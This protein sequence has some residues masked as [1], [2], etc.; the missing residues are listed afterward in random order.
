MEY[1]SPEQLDR[2]AGFIKNYCRNSNA[3]TASVLDPNANVESK[4]IATLEWELNKDIFIQLNRHLMTRK[5]TEI[6]GKEQA[7][8]YLQQIE[9]HLIYVHDE[10]SLKPYCASVSLYPLLLKGTKTVGGNSEVP[11]DADSFALA[12]TELVQILSS[13]FAGAIATVEFLTYADY[14]FR[15]SYGAD[16]LETRESCAERFFRSVVSTINQPACGRGFQGIFWNISLYDRD[17][18]DGIFENF[19]FPDG[20]QPD[21][22]STERLQ[23]YFMHWFNNAR[24]KDLLT[25]PVITAAMLTKNGK[26]VSSR[27]SNFCADE[28]SEGN[29]FFIYMSDTADSLSGCCRLRSEMTDTAFS[30][31]LGAGGVST[32]SVRVM[33]LNK[34]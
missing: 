22:E 23:N 3:A 13:Q 31:T 17:F 5:I 18:F 27:F 30:H 24:T 16:Y 34:I 19:R 1:L 10:T 25:F 14:F 33:T 2:K 12:F 8:R 15:K 26:P 9:D 11:F 4:N 28:L 29:S 32:G 6:A 7:E 21:Y 20:E